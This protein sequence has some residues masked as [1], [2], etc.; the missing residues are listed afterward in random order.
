M[1][2]DGSKRKRERQGNEN[3]TEIRVE[4]VKRGNA[5][6]VGRKGWEEKRLKRIK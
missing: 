1:S 3:E 5:E 6:G 4:E 2:E